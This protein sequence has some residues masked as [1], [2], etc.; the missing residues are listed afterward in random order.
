MARKLGELTAGW[1]PER[2]A[3]VKA[4]AEEMLREMPLTSLRHHRDISQARLAEAMGTS[5]R[6]VARIE[7][8]SHLY[9][10][11]L[12]KYVEAMGGTLEVTA[13][14][15]ESEIRLDQWPPRLVND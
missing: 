15:P 9:L 10:T 13:R 6:Q 8:R 2:L 1:S 14:F 4:R 7:H 11:A 12:R 3:S 5:E